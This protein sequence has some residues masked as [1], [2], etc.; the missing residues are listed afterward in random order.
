MERE[1]LYRVH[2]RGEEV[3]SEGVCVVVQ[4]LHLQDKNEERDCS[5]Y[6]YYYY[7]YYDCF[8]VS[9]MNRVGERIERE[10]ERDMGWGGV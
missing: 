7:Y 9:L 4:S 10:R 6:Y 2:Q 3:K 8:W 5:Y 1:G